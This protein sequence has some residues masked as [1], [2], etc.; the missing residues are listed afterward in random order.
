MRFLYLFLVFSL[1][2]RLDAQRYKRHYEIG[3]AYLNKQNYYEARRIFK[4]LTAKKSKNLPQLRPYI[5]FYWAISAYHIDQKHESLYATEKIL[6]EYKDWSKIDEV[7]YL[8]GILNFERLRGLKAV[9]HFKYIRDNSFRADIENAL[10]TYLDS[11][12][13]GTLFELY[14]IYPEDTIIRNTFYEKLKA[15]RKTPA[16]S[17]LFQQL[18]KLYKLSTP[19]QIRAVIKGKYR[20]AIL[21]SRRKTDAVNYINPVLLEFILAAKLAAQELKTETINLDFFVFN[22]PDDSTALSD[23]KTNL[24]KYPCD[25]FLSL[26]H[27][28]YFKPIYDLA[29]ELELPFLTLTSQKELIQ[30]NPLICSLLPSLETMLEAGAKFMIDS[31]ETPKAFIIQDNTTESATIAKLYE[32][33]ILEQGGQIQDIIV[34]NN[35]RGNFQ[36]N[37]V[38][39]RE[40]MTQMADSLDLSHVFVITKSE[41]TLRKALALLK[42][43]SFKQPILGQQHWFESRQVPLNQME[44]AKIY[45]LINHMIEENQTYWDFVDQYTSINKKM[46]NIYSKL[47]YIATHFLGSILKKYGLDFYKNLYLEPEFKIKFFSDIYFETYNENQNVHVCTFENGNLVKVN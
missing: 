29:S 44:E 9:R 33:T 13:Y 17:A 28:D 19:T 11:L 22:I 40:A 32:R 4:D 47:G 38:N 23:L 39:F 27:K 46:P 45:F 26:V 25:L 35:D 8:T 42:T 5:L 43:S 3:K 20:V 30:K 31:L 14:E 6:T 41:N 1:F 24:Q 16:E 15:R 18:T 2:F 12:P 37:L 34:F 10:N 36:K 21:L 7:H